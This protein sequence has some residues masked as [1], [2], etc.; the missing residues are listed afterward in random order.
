MKET[1]FSL[2]A[3]GHAAL[4]AWARGLYRLE[5]IDRDRVPKS[6]GA[7]VA[8][9]HSSFLDIPA[10]GCT[11]PRPVSFV[12]RETLLSIPILG[13]LIR[14]WGAILIQRGAADAAAIRAIVEAAK[15]GRLVVMYPEGTRSSTDALQE[16]R[17]GIVLIARRAGVPVVPAGVA[18]TREIFPRTRKVPRLRGRIDVAYGEPLDLA[19]GA[20]ADALARLRAAMLFQMDRAWTRWSERTGRTRPTAAL[21][22]SP[23]ARDV[24]HPASL[25]RDAAHPDLPN[26]SP[27]AVSPESSGAPTSRDPND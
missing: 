23:P 8:A 1:D 24:S 15:G 14:H 11:C 5:A 7:I 3:P 20:P 22:A 6:G 16:L 2:Y 18:G 21:L 17:A 25:R 10:V 9:N 19:V 13:W 26:T 4:K 27:T 12:A